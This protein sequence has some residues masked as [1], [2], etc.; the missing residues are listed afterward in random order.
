MAK[1]QKSNT[2]GEAAGNGQSRTVPAGY[3]KR[4]TEVTGFWVSGAKPVHFIPR[5]ARAVDNSQTAT[6]PSVLI[7]GEAVGDENEGQTTDGEVIPIKKGQLI[8]VWYKPGM[9]AIKELAG[10]PVY[11]WQEGLRDT[12]KK[13]KMKLYEVLSPKPGDELIITGDFRRE[14]AKSDLPFKVLGALSEDTPESY[15]D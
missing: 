4:S 8:G 11:M 7:I 14:S 6:R 3:S 2:S 1:G 12:G 15:A 9:L 13:D 5:F 10:V